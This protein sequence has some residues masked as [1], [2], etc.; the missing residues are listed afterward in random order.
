MKLIQRYPLNFNGKST[1]ELTDSKVIY[2]YKAFN[3]SYHYDFLISDISP[4][5]ARAKQGDKSLQNL[6]WF[7]GICAYLS[8]VFFRIS[9]LHFLLLLG[10]LAVFGLITLICILL[11]FF[12]KY[13]YE[14]FRGKNGETLFWIKHT[15]M[16]EEK[17]FL[18]E[19][20]KRISHN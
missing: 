20:K 17:T 16:G 13:E 8:S 5:V 14:V 10:L 2:D 18:E 19:L 4:L 3:T 1:Y 9:K 12:K 6:A 15:S 11:Y 7:F